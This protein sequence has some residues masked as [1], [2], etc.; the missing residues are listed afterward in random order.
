[1]TRERRAGFVCT[2]R[3]EKIDSKETSWHELTW[4]DAKKR[5]DELNARLQEGGYHSKFRLAIDRYG[6]D[7]IFD[8]GGELEIVDTVEDAEL[9]MNEFLHL[10]GIPGSHKSQ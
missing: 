2:I 9:I 10:S 8:D 5:L 4:E 1:M 6:W 3:S 7:V